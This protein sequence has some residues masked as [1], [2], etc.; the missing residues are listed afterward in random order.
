MKKLAERMKNLFQK[1]VFLYQDMV[2]YLKD[3]QKSLMEANVEILWDFSDKKHACASQIE[4]TRGKILNLLDD[5]AIEHT[6]EVSTFNISEVVSLLPK[7]ARNHIKK[8]EITVTTLK[9]NARSLA[10]QNKTFVEEY[11]KVIDDLVGVITDAEKS[12]TVYNK[13]RYPETKSKTNLLM[14]RE[15]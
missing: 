15:V 13:E 11:L 4:E 14:H 8:L 1:K 3:E 10:S 2:Q 9:E 5:T 12:G 6:M 7:E